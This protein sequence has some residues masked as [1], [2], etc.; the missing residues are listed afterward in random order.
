[1]SGL[2]TCLN[3]GD[4][5]RMRTADGV[6]ILVTVARRIGRQVKLSINAP[7]TVRIE[8]EKNPNP[9]KEHHNGEYPL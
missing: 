2:H 6:P 4:T 7:R 1:M 3:V 9:N 8:R 5:L